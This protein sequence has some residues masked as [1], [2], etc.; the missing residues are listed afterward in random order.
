MLKLTLVNDD[1]VEI[2]EDTE[3]CIKNADQLSSLFEGTAAIYYVDPD[4]D[5]DTPYSDP[6]DML[7][8]LRPKEAIDETYIR[9]KSA[10]W[11]FARGYQTIHGYR[12]DTWQAF[13]QKEMNS[14]CQDDARWCYDVA[15][16]GCENGSVSSLIHTEDILKVLVEHSRD[17][18]HKIREIGEDYQDGSFMDFSQFTFSNL[19]WMC[20]EQTVKD[21]LRS[22]ELEDI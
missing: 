13:V 3:N 22:I 2:N 11:N 12:P 17:I 16:R 4:T 1:T 10:E 15:L 18:E 5:N 20:Y 8:N 21:V 14:Y 6:E 9:I 7:F 19:I